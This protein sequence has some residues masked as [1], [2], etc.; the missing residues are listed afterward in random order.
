MKIISSFVLVGLFI[1]SQSGLVMAATASQTYQTS[2]TVPV[3]S[4]VS[5]QA[6]S[7]NA[8]GTPVF[9]SMG[10]NTS[11]NFDPMTFNTTTQIYVPN[12]YYAIN[13]GPGAGGGSGSV[14]AT[15]T[16]TEGANPNNVSGGTTHGLG[17][18]TVATFVKTVGST[19]TVMGAHP[20]T[21]LID[22]IGGV[23]ISTT[24]TAGG[25]FRMYLGVETNPTAA[26]EPAG[27]EVISAADRPGNYT[28]SV[29]I[30]ATVV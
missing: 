25:T 10:S 27:V 13:V 16:Y 2:A 6:F 12:N 4:A 28:G 14:S 17:Y 19:E 30:S 29:L 18:K 9:T 24:D 8:T 11:L 23:N 3:A 26:G 20:K 15:I 5:I 1:F 22:M 7:V 21:K